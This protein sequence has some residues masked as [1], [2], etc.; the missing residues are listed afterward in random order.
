[1]KE[2]KFLFFS[3]K[4]KGNFVSSLFPVQTSPLSRAFGPRAC[5]RRTV[6]CGHQVSTTLPLLRARVNN[7][8][9]YACCVDNT[10]TLAQQ[11][12]QHSCLC[13]PL[14]TKPPP[15]RFSIK[16]TPAYAC[17]CHQQLP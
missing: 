12:Q 1:M 8:L 13:T 15:M 3:V 5:Q 7:T 17:Q 6:A 16:K 4:W 11:Y 9:A 2:M 10:F 14:S